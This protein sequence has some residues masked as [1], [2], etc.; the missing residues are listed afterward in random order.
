MTFPLFGG[1]K[2]DNFEDFQKTALVEVYC[3]G[4]NE[5]RKMNA[6]FAKYLNGTIESCSKCKQLKLKDDPFDD[7]LR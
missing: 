6:V 3:K 5:P 4:C 2:G 7:P 1:E